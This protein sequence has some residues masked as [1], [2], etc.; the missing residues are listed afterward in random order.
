MKMNNYMVK[1]YLSQIIDQIFRLA[2]NLS[3]NKV[4][5]RRY[6]P[7]RL[8]YNLSRLRYSYLPLRH[9]LSLDDRL[10]LFY[11]NNLPRNLFARY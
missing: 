6:S 8:K 10:H 2:S 7:Y 4:K 9:T 3:W 5:L 11:F 1:V